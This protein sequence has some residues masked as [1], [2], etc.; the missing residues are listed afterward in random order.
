MKTL[1][2]LS[3]RFKIPLWGSVLVFVTAIAVSGLVMVEAYNEL[4]EDLVIDAKTL[5]RA[6]APGLFPIMLQDNVWGAYEII[7]NPVVNAPT[8]A[9][10]KAENILV[11]DNSLRVFAAALPAQAPVLSDLRQLSPEF[12]VLAERVA[13]MDGYES[14][15]IE[16]PDSDHLYYVTP[17]ARE[18]AHIGKLIVMF[19]KNSFMPRFVE[20]AWRGL[21]GG[22]MVL[23]LLLPINW[24]WGWHMAQPLVRLTKHMGEFG[25]HQPDDID[26]LL[27]RHHDELGRLIVVY[28][29]MLAELKAKGEME[30][31]IVQSERLAALGQLAAGVAHEINNPLGGMLTAIDTLRHHNAA[32]PRTMKT[33]SLIER[34]LLQIKDTVGALLVEAKLKSRDFEPQDIEDVR[35]L[36]TPQVR[37]KSLHIEWHDN[38]TDTVQIPATLVRQ[39][40]INLLLNAVEAAEQEGN[41]S[42]SVQV[43]G[44]NLHISV[45]ND[46]KTLS[47]QQMTHLFEPF[48]PL[49]ESGHG[50]G[51]WV[52]YQI[53]HQL[54]GHIAAN[55]DD[56]CM[57]FSVDIPFGEGECRNDT[58]ISA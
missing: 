3:F 9:P 18:D 53:A 2:D 27:Y 50:L 7:R 56:G 45:E 5:S 46:G 6:L 32:D 28:N 29:Q 19:T 22:L 14:S 10:A 49:S 8:D 30:R 33:I 44:G 55:N 4:K 52:T 36:L 37:H 13:A 15:V 38:L 26:P 23:G 57:R 20:I 1:L 51:L 24:Y 39:I 54:G 48:S 21:W 34:G 47:E 35:M 25:K 43:A 17:I 11:I 16:F 31:Q 58:P 12:A 42:C 41:I 40:L